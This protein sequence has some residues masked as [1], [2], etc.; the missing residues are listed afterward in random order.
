MGDPPPHYHFLT[1]G[2]V[3]IVSYSCQG[4]RKHWMSYLF[5]FLHVLL[6]HT[7]G[8]YRHPFIVIDAFPNIAKTPGSDGMLSRLDELPGND[9]G[10]W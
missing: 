6:V 4:N 1:K 8:L 5:Y 2:L 7:E 10:G 9:V 3:A